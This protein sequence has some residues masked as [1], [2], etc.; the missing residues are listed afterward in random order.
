MVWI[1][2]VVVIFTPGYSPLCCVSIV[3]SVSIFTSVNSLLST[4][5]S[6]LSINFFWNGGSATGLSL[7]VQI[8]SGLL[9]SIFVVMLSFL[10]FSFVEYIMEELFVGSGHRYIHANIC[11]IVLFVL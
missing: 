1:E 4:F 5:Y 9:I 8:I 6:P 3:S 10:S 11:S 2:L 7:A